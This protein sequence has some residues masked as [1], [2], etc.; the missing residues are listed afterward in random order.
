MNVLGLRRHRQLITVLPSSSNR[1]RVALAALPKYSGD[2]GRRRVEVEGGVC[3]RTSVS[4]SITTTTATITTTNRAAASRNGNHMTEPSFMV[5][6]AN[7]R[8]NVGKKAFDMRLVP[9]IYFLGFQSNEGTCLRTLTT[10]TTN[11]TSS[12]SSSS[13]HDSAP[14]IVVED[15]HA[16]YNG[17]ILPKTFDEWEKVRCIYILCDGCLFVC[18]F[19]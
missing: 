6:E 5:K 15:C 9:Q 12:S 13:S 2:V 18:L 7:N 17:N 11:T 3:R 14:S 4:T 16:S 10:I 1:I 8:V 19:V